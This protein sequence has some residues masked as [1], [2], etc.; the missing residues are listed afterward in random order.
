MT[1]KQLKIFRVVAKNN[2][3]SKAAEE[4]YTTQPYLSR[5]IKTLEDELG[6]KLL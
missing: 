1:E 2:N 5:Q 3:I 6:V 4:L